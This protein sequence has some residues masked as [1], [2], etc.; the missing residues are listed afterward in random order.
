M[1][2]L[3]GTAS[4]PLCSGVTRRDLLRAGSLSVLGL[5]LADLLR[6]EAAQAATSAVARPRA[7]NVILIYLG[8]GLTHHDTFDP[9]PGA[10]Q[11]IRGK[12]GVIPTKTPGV[13]FTEQMP[14]L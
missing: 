2:T 12:Y 8:G 9:K 3:H 7:K 10:P 4:S 5:S 14:D 1:L 11:E 6:A 13:Q